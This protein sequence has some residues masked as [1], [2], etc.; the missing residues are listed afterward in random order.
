MTNHNQLYDV[1]IGELKRKIPQNPVLVKM[2]IDILCLEKE[3]IYRRLRHEV[4]F[5]FYEIALISKKL[6]I[7]LD[8][9]VGAATETSTP[10]QL[11]TP[12]FINPQSMDYMAFSA[13]IDVLKTMRES[14]EAKSAMLT[15][16]VPHELF[17]GY[18]HLTRYNIFN[19]QVHCSKEQPKP[20]HA[21]SF[22]E[23]VENEFQRLYTESKYIP[24]YF[25]FDKH[26][27]RR[28]VNS[29]NYFNSIRLIEKND[30]LKVK[31]DLLQ[32]IDY[33]EDM[34]ISGV[35]KE[36]GFPACLYISDMDITSNY[37]YMEAG[38]YKLT[39]FKTFLLT[40]ATSVNEQ[41]FEKV[42]NWIHSFIRISSL[43]T[44]TNEKQRLLYFEKQRLIVN[45]L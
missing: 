19:W 43:I 34:A 13:C 38:S 5:T 18:R 37:S 14:K 35:F 28:L 23:Q 11:R 4:P 6:G 24:T 31:E 12:D 21:L 1:F 22:P 29:I 39:F 8:N 32:M 33:I 26:I 2:L 40:Y 30:I 36:T 27:F 15:N 9:I 16:T 7:S 41:L 10:L 25:I 45:E 20:F 3:A 42:K 17:S 44:V